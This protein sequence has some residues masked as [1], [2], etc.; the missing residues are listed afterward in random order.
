[1]G[2]MDFYKGS[3]K[4]FKPKETAEVRRQVFYKD[5]HAIILIDG[6]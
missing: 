4:A 3:M 6:V 1:M 2:A 5:L